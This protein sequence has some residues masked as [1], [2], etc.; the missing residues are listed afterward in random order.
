MIN[1]VILMMQQVCLL[2]PKQI[3]MIVLAGATVLLN[4]VALG[5]GNRSRSF[6]HAH[7]LLK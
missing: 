7:S 5:F 4:R 3:V 6:S 1:L 2:T